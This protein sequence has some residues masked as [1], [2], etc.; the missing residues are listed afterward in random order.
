MRRIA[1]RLGI[2]APSLYKH[3]PDKQA[4]E[5]AIISAA[6]EEQ[7]EAVRAR[8]RRAATTRSPRSPRPTARFALAHPHL[9]RLMTDQ[10]LRRDLLVPGVEERA[11][12]TVYR[13]AGE[14]ADR[15]RA[16]WAFAH[17]MALLEIANRFPPGADIDAAWREGIGAFRAVA[18]RWDAIVVGSGPNGL[19]AA[20][21]LAQAGR[22]VLVLEA[23]RR[24]SAAARAPRSS[25]CPG[26]RHD[27]CSAIHPLALAS[28]FLRSLPLR[29][30]RARVR[31]PRDPARAS[32]GRRH[33][34]GCC[35]A[36]S[37]RR[38]T[39]SASTRDAYRALMRPLAA[40]W[41]ALLEDLLGPLRPPRHPIADARFA[42][43]GLRSATGLA[44][45]RFAGAPRAS[46]ARR[47]RRALDATA[48][49]ARR[50]PAS[51]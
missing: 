17:G 1:E 2:R 39:D 46:A 42:R 47:Q 4:L 11:G 43:A 10:E 34:R 40:G 12:L 29:R 36:R 21:A 26:F 32:A 22:S 6:F 19:A 15:A 24:R 14:D 20:I 25:R 7:A 38:P 16:A 44:R 13:A 30:A 27:V 51:G 8:R 45:S 49:G 31:P 5:A 9:Y 48:H 23:A 41:E 3:F 37:T 35:T 18:D 33:G 28:P 50:R